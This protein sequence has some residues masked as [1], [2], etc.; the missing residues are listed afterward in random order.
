VGYDWFMLHSRGWLTGTIRTM[1][2][3]ERSIWADLLAMASESRVRGVICRA[4]NIPYTRK[5]IADFL[6]VPIKVL[7]NTIEKC[8]TDKNAQDSTHRIEIDEYGC[9][10]IMN[11]EKYQTVPEPIKSRSKARQNDVPM[12]PEDAHAKRQALA[13]KYGYLEPEAA[14]RGAQHREVEETAK[15]HNKL[16]QQYGT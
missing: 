14:K 10:H 2:M 16:L 7:N 5:Y 15:H 13:A 11:W 8:L 1:S 6:Q 9:I 4:V 12:S 3:E